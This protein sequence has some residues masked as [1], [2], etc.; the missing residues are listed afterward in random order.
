MQTRRGAV[1][2]SSVINLNAKVADVVGGILDHV[3]G[4]LVLWTETTVPRQEQQEGLGA[5]CRICRMPSA[6]AGCLKV[7][8][9]VDTAKP[10]GR[11]L[12]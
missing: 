11:F 3:G 6:A 10:V 8:E 2:V 5:G 1:P 9:I 12:Q 4:G 7:A